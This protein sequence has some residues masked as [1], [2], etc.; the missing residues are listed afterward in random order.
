[1][2][3]IPGA[4]HGFTAKETRRLIIKQYPLISAFQELKGALQNP[5]V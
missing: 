5:Y 4:H 1:M 3:L 2:Q